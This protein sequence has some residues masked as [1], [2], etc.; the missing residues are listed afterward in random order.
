MFQCITIRLQNLH[1]RNKGIVCHGGG[2]GGGGG[3]LPHHA[4]WLALFA[5]LMNYSLILAYHPITCL[6]ST[7]SATMLMPSDVIYS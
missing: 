2:G 5:L 6:F 1:T 3:G 7:N 4:T